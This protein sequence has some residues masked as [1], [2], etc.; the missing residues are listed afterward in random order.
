MIMNPSYECSHR[1]ARFPDYQRLKA[2]GN[3]TVFN[4]FTKEIK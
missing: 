4:S 1:A 3:H 2:T